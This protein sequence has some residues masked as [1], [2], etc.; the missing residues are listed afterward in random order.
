MLS[1]KKIL[2][3]GHPDGSGIVNYIAKFKYSSITI[4]QINKLLEEIQRDFP[5]ITEN[6]VTIK[7]QKSTVILEFFTYDLP[8]KDSGLFDEEN[9]IKVSNKH[10][11][12]NDDSIFRFHFLGFNTI[13][14]NYGLDIKELVDWPYAPFMLPQKMS[15]QNAFLI[16]SYLIKKIE[17]DLNLEEC[18]Q[19]AITILNDNLEKFHFKPVYNFSGNVIDL[20]TIS[21]NMNRF[22]KSEY[23]T[24]YFEWFTENIDYET[25]K[26][27]Y[28]NYGYNFKEPKF[29]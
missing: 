11:A 6:H 13:G 29:S 24:K 1:L 25:V 5:K 14:K 23:Y 27:I 21:G 19:K 26:N 8:K 12:Y 4:F 10:I 15:S 22:K 17:D 3:K 7:I 20:F 28:A 18:S 2:K 16:L 9:Y